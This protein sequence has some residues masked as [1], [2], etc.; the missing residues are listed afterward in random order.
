[1][2]PGTAIP[3]IANT[4]R[5]HDDILYIIF[6]RIVDKSRLEESLY[7]TGYSFISLSHVCSHWRRVIITT[8]TLWS[9]IFYDHHNL[10][11]LALERSRN[12]PINVV[13][14]GKSQVSVAL[15]LKLG[16]DSLDGRR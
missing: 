5:L 3:S 1:M 12:A 8:P 10:A 4:C 7:G 6:K 2:K 14:A 9:N 11:L 15:N 16:I 13:Y